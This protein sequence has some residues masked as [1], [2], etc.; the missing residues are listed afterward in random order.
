VND[1]LM[2]PVER[3]E[4]VARVRTQL[5][6]KRYSDK[7]RHSLQLSLEMAITD[8]LTGLFNR[9][10]MSRHLGT[11]IANANSTGKPVSFL[12][13]DIDFFKQVNDTHGH[14]I[15]DEVLREFATR[16]SANVR[17]IDLACRYGGE[18]F[19][20][21]MP[22][23]DLNFAYMVA[24]RLRQA[25]ADAP[26]RISSGPGQLP[27]TISIGVTASEGTGDTAEA[28]LKRAD[29]ALYRAKR[30]GRNRVVADAA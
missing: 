28:L 1:Y 2:R 30:D 26:F 13:L 29:Q 4:L 15:G 6:R 18:E 8:Q 17:G 7:L 9:R 12:I 14:D 25:V 27:V 19:V 11:L 20:V 16:I 24:E 23:T 3:S 5:R 21:V 22:D 10:Y